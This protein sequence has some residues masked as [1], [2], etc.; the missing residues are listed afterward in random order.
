[1]KLECMIK[2]TIES[3]K[4]D[5]LDEFFKNI[6]KGVRAIGLELDTKRRDCVYKFLRLKSKD[7]FYLKEIQGSKMYLD[8]SDE[9]ICKELVFSDIREKQATIMMH[10]IL[11][12]G[13]IVVDIGANIGYY[14]LLEA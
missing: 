5:S 6:F 14:A 12:E 1:M 11:K 8:L 10:K 3:F 2:R 13:D 4:E 7:G 9:G